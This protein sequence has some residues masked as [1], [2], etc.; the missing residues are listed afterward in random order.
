MDP[1]RRANPGQWW[2][3]RA[4]TAAA[5]IASATLSGGCALERINA[6]APGKEEC[7]VRGVT[8]VYALGRLEARLPSET[9][10]EA[11]VAA[12]RQGLER[13]GY[14]I[15]AASA[16][17]DDGYVRGHGGHR[18]DTVVVRAAN[19]F[20]KTCVRVRVWP[21]SDRDQSL[22]IMDDVL[23]RLGY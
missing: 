7:E 14:T 5:L 10:V 8:S 15:K 1:G 12:A 11:V 21:M 6:P 20:E 2:A 18:G 13:R 4:W 23:A 17:R 9:R 22:S 16:T 19:E 3:R